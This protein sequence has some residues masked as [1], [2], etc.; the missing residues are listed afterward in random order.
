MTAEDQ[1]MSIKS[2]LRKLE[3]VAPPAP[4]PFFTVTE[5]QRGKILRAMVRRGLR[6]P[7]PFPDVPDGEYYRHFSPWFQELKESVGQGT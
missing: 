4:G 1:G 3:A 5:E 6:W 7:D 2:R